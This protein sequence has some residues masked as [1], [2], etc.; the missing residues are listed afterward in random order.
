MQSSSRDLKKQ[1]VDSLLAKHTREKPP[2]VHEHDSKPPN[3]TTYSKRRP[4]EISDLDAIS[5]MLYF[6]L[7]AQELEAGL[8]ETAEDRLYANSDDKFNIS[9]AEKPIGIRIG[10]PE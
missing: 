5:Q 7:S 1:S 3:T 9:G 2:R 6:P 8:E 10:R 4:A